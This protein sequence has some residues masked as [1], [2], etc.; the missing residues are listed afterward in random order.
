MTRARSVRLSSQHSL[1]VPS[2]T[3]ERVVVGPVS[4]VRNNALLARI[5]LTTRVFLDYNATFGVF[6]KKYTRYANG[7]YAYVPVKPP[8]FPLLAAYID[9][10]AAYTRT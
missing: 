7:R 8:L 6:K 1:I 10:R 2:F 9:T 3:P 5:L 4:T